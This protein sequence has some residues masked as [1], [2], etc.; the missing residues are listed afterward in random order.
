MFGN[1]KAHNIGLCTILKQPY[2]NSQN[3]N[4]DL[5]LFD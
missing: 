2:N 5:K 3:Y 4:I 1:N